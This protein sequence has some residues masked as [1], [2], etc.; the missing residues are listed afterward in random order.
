MSPASSKIRTESAVVDIGTSRT[1]ASSPTLMLRL[2]SACMICSRT[3]AES[4]WAILRRL[5]GRSMVKS[6][7]LPSSSSMAF[8]SSCSGFFFGLLVYGDARTCP[9][10]PP[11]RPRPSVAPS[12]AF[13]SFPLYHTH[14]PQRNGSCKFELSCRISYIYEFKQKRL[15]R[16]KSKNEFARQTRACIY[17]RKRDCYPF[18]PLRGG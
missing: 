3:G 14:P 5:S 7:C 6:A 18:T 16:A 15:W 17:A 4:A 1:C 8:T 9:C 2:D 13:L 11:L 10:S 12:G